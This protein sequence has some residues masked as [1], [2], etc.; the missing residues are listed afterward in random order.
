MV[1]PKTKPSAPA[2]ASS[3]T[4]VPSK[5]EPVTPTEP[6]TP[7]PAIPTSPTPVTPE[8]VKIDEEADLEELTAEEK[9]LRADI[10]KIDEKYAASLKD[11][12]IRNAWL[13]GFDAEEAMAWKEMGAFRAPVPMMFFTSALIVKSQKS[14]IEEHKKALKYLTPLA[15]K[16]EAELGL[17]VKSVPPEVLANPPAYLKAA[18]DT[19][20]AGAEEK[21]MAVQKSLDS[22][23][24]L[25]NEMAK[26]K[27]N[28]AKLFKVI[29]D[30]LEVPAIKLE[31][32]ANLLG[33]SWGM[34]VREEVLPAKVR[35]A[36]VISKMAYS[37]PKPIVEPILT[38]AEKA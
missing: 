24:V 11:S 6:V 34:D 9:K 30:F 8:V 4:P 19:I 23:K 10:A 15:A 1:T 38:P 37:I 29:A 32:G 35:N 28:P 14:K 26:S 33:G 2:E 12:A 16:A 13:A 22:I 25:N 31:A 20:K 18:F 36:M 3:P 7:A 17:I 5:V 21:R 27:K